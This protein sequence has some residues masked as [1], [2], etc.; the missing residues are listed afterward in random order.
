MQISKMELGEE[1]IV[2]E[3]A[4]EIWFETY[5]DILSI[6]QIIYMLNKYLSKEA[7]ARGIKEDNYEYFLLKDDDIYIGFY[8][9]RH[10]SDR[11][12]LSKAY[13]VKDSR[14][15]GYFKKIMDNVFENLRRKE[16]SVY[17][18]VNKNNDAKDKYLSIGFD[19]IDEV[20]S[21]IGG[22][23]VMDDYIMEITR[24]KYEENKTNVK[25]KK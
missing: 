19:I 2:E 3:L 20:K 6:G 4:R 25:Y 22:G 18:T 15:K 10:E 11:L 13:I 17:L 9:V 8:A 16:K 14:G 7:V 24:E 12:F 23:Y 5:A 21:D 1:H